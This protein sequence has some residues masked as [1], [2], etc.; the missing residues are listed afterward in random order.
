[1]TKAIFELSWGLM[2]KENTNFYV[3]SGFGSWSPPV[4]IGN[5]PEVVVFNLKFE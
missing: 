4:R 3:S 2:K 5:R 1:M